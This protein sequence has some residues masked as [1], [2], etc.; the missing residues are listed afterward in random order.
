MNALDN[1]REAALN[2]IDEAEKNFK[3]WLIGAGFF[4][5]LLLVAYFFCMNIHNRLHW[6]ILIAALLTYGTLCFV[7]FS[8]KSY[9]NLCNIRILKAIQAQS[10]ILIQGSSD[11]SA[12][13]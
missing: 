3:R 9:I 6:L 1:V 7:L 11:D 5:G 2:K 10:N 4:E 8:L 12:S 13:K